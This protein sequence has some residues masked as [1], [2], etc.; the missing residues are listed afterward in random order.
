MGT[1][2]T[3]MVSSASTTKRPLVVEL[4]GPA[5][6]G[7]STLLQAL[8]QGDSAI[9]AGLPVSKLNYVKTAFRLRSAFLSL[10]APYNGLLWKEM[11]RILYLETLYR[12]LQR[13]ASKDYEAI[14]F[15]EGPVYMLSRLRVFGKEGIKS[16]RFKELWQLA[17]GQ[18]A[19]A[20]DVIVWLD[21]EDLIL[22]QRI[23]MRKQPY[24]VKDTTDGSLRELFARYR[25]A[26]RQVISELTSTDG[27]TIVRLVTDRESMTHTVE[28]IKST[29][30]R[31]R[32]AWLPLA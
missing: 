2:V 12:T 32:D 24:P 7:K 30:D 4:V 10:H 20:V 21:A 5:G 22:A 15:D 16:D 9:R 8:T 25:A 13:E 31:E 19:D 3:E 18:W 29:L 17:V 1:V 14:I 6:V 11:K 27:P 23:R 28:K 26:F